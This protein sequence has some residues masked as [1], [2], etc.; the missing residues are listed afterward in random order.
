MGVGAQETTFPR[1]EDG[2]RWVE[3]GQR[4]TSRAHG[5]VIR[6]VEGYQEK[7]LQS[8][9]WFCDDFPTESGFSDG[10]HSC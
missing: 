2:P 1:E 7:T 4:F 9:L 3:R 8:V 10:D 6:Y 5:G